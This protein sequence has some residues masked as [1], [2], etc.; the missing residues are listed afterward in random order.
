MEGHQNENLGSNKVLP[1]GMGGPKRN[2]KGEEL[3]KYDKMM[4]DA[5]CRCQ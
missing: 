3:A 1:A 4:L 5:I 2:T